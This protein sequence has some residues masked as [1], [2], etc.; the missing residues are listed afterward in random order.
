MRTFYERRSIYL[1]V[2]N[3]VR[4]QASGM[5]LVQIKCAMQWYDSRIGGHSELVLNSP[6]EP[7]N[8]RRRRHGRKIRYGRKRAQKC[9]HNIRDSAIFR[10]ATS[11]PR[12][13]AP[14]RSR[15]PGLFCN[16]PR[17]LRH[18]NKESHS[19]GNKPLGESFASLFRSLCK[20]SVSKICILHYI[21]VYLLCFLC[22]EHKS[23]S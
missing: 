3:N 18:V 15:I 8:L 17:N 21:P 4:S 19:F 22:P 11:P 6:A 1:S 7:C 14:W 20:I 10:T 23:I 9:A 16:L 2:G 5:C 13:T 12:M